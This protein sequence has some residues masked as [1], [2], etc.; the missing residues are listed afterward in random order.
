MKRARVATNRWTQIDSE[1]FNRIRTAI[2]LPLRCRLCEEINSGI[3]LGRYTSV[4]RNI[5]IELA[6]RLKQE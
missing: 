4:R 3:P 6:L 5:D 1:A 2:T